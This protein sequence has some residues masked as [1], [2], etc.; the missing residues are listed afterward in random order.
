MRVQ[1]YTFWQG[2][3][4]I[5][6]STLVDLMSRTILGQTLATIVDFEP[7]GDQETIFE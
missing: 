4:I 5:K 1:N 7:L 3:G 6:N 2:L